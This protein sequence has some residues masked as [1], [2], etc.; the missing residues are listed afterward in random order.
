MNRLGD[1]LYK[2][3]FIGRWYFWYNLELAALHAVT[4]KGVPV[5][6][7]RALAEEAQALDRERRQTQTAIFS[8]IRNYGSVCAACGACCK[9]KVDRYTAFGKYGRDILSLPWMLAN[10]ITHTWSRAAHAVTRRPLP[11]S[12]VCENLG[13]RGCTLAHEDR[14]MLC[15]SW[16]CPKYLRHVSTDDLRRIAPRLREMERLHFR[17]WGLLRKGRGA[18]HL[19]G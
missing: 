11:E 7:S 12:G 18:S 3:A 19:G 16:F 10:G 13:E 14:P 15:A 1:L 9:E 8:I 2:T 4:P 5:W 6:G 17:A